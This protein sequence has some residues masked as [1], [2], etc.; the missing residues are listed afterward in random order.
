MKEMYYTLI[1]GA[2]R[3]F[4]RA[5]AREC[6]RRGMNLLLTSLPGEDLPTLARTLHEEYGIRTDHFI[7]DLTQY[8]APGDLYRWTQE[9]K[10]KVQHLINNAG[11]GAV[12]PFVSKDAEFYGRQVDIN[13]KALVMLTRYFVEDL[14]RT[15]EAR[16]LNISS[17]AYIAP[18]PYKIVYSTT[19]A[20]IYGFSRSLRQEYI[21]TSLRVCVAIPGP[22]HTNEIV[23]KRINDQGTLGR[24]IAWQPERAAR[25]CI[26]GMLK[27]KAFILPGF[28]E[29]FTFAMEKIIPLSFKLRMIAG[30]FRKNPPS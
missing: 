29:R 15:P 18:M 24:A 2:G 16:I 11:I 26:T 7:T 20:F 22:M 4:G 6:A 5:M 27:G 10:Y 30:G 3:G 28:Y 12:G 8:D 1:T 14:A 9:K 23:T 13:I 25:I 17:L 19:K 21:D